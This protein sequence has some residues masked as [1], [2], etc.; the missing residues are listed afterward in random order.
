MAVSLVNSSTSSV[1]T[2]DLG[3]PTTVEVRSVATVATP[4]AVDGT[5]VVEDDDATDFVQS[6]C[7]MIWGI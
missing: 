2:L 7:F 6:V 5:L 1:P 3:L 4:A